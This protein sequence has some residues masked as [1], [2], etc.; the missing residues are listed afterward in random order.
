[1]SARKRIELLSL[2]YKRQTKQDL[3]LEDINVT[4]KERIIPKGC[5]VFL[6]EGV[7][8]IAINE[9]SA[10]KKYLKTQ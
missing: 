7:E 5:K 8:I 10:R 2:E 1:M 3:K 6:I 4:H 9:K